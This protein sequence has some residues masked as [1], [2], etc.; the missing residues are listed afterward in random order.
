MKA[1]LK[2]GIII[3]LIYLIIQIV[4]DFFYVFYQIM[5]LETIRHYIYLDF[6]GIFEPVVRQCGGFLEVCAIGYIVILGFIAGVIIGTLLWLIAL[7]FKRKNKKKK[8][9][10]KPQD[11]KEIAQKVN[12]QDKKIKETIVT[13]IIKKKQQ[14][15]PRPEVKKTEPK[16]QDPEQLKDEIEDLLKQMKQTIKEKEAEVAEIE[17]E[18]PKPKVRKKTPKKAAKKIT[19]K[20]SK[21]KTKRTK[22]K[23]TPKEKKKTSRTARKKKKNKRK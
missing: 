15:M 4:D 12:E 3:G 21:N 16:T 23:E 22:K 17:Q 14:I 9:F 11:I 20:T 8:I 1:W 2:G 18:T 6:L 13:Q 5:P 10:K 19:K 7:L